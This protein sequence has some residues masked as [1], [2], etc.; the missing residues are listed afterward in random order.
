MPKIRL[1]TPSSDTLI[2]PLTILDG[3]ASPVPLI[4][5]LN[6]VKSI[7]LEYTIQRG[8]EYQTGRLMVVNDGTDVTVTD[9]NA[10]TDFMVGVIF[11]ADISGSN[12][13]I[14]YISSMTGIPASIRYYEKKWS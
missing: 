1:F 13:Y 3:Q 9:D 12:L 10:D 11:S 8:P 4:S 5:Y 7:H 14:N 6:T 2:G